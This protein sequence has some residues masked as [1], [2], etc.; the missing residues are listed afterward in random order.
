MSKETKQANVDRN[1]ILAF[2]STKHMGQWTQGNDIEKHF[3][4]KIPG[5]TVGVC[6]N[7]FKTQKLVDYSRNMDEY[8]INADGRNFVYAGGYK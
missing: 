8:K 4:D 3:S 2:L 6:L 7:D 5:Y 1:A